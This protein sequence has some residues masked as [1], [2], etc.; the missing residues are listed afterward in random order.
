M[1][2]LRNRV[3]IASVGPVMTG[4]LVAAG[5]PPDIVPVNPKMGALV[6]AAAEEA[7]NVLATKA[8]G[9]R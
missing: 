2:T 5:L 3:A 6:K 1:D 7:A 4:A 8:R 9:V